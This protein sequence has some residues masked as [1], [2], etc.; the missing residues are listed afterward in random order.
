MKPLPW[1]MDLFG[2]II[3]CVGFV[4]LSD[5]GG[6]IKTGVPVSD[7]V[8]IVWDWV[9]LDSFLGIN[10]WLAIITLATGFLSICHS[11]EIRNDSAK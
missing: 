5:R 1:L 9:R 6:A 11:I 2:A 4:L 3:V 7:P 8:L 10:W